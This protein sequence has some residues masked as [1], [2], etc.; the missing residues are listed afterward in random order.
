MY[1]FFITI[2]RLAMPA[3]FRLIDITEFMMAITILY[4]PVKMVLNSRQHELSSRQQR[5]EVFVARALPA[6]GS[7][8]MPPPPSKFWKLSR[9]GRVVS[10]DL[11]SFVYTRLALWEKLQKYW[12]LTTKAAHFHTVMFKAFLGPSNFRGSAWKATFRSCTFCFYAGWRSQPA[13]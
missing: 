13:S 1:C 6:R 12:L 7:G 8:G 5:P 3:L 4:S 11:K 10:G 2:F 9:C